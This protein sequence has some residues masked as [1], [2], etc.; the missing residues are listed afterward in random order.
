MKKLILFFLPLLAMAACN[1]EPET[2]T[3]TEVVINS[4]FIND[5][6]ELT[7]TSVESS[8]SLFNYAVSRE[9]P[10]YTSSSFTINKNSLP[11]SYSI[12]QTLTCKPNDFYII[13]INKGNTSSFYFYNTIPVKEFLKTNP[14]TFILTDSFDRGQ[15]ITLNLSYIY[16]NR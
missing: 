7:N 14:S 8:I 5:L 3:D 2:L 13:S 1:S 12:G 10:I 11:Y 16:F 15:K 6:P 4:V 9:T